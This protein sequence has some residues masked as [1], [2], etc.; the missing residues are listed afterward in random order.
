MA[1]LVRRVANS[2]FWYENF[3][4]AGKRFRGSLKTADHAVAARLAADRMATAKAEKNQVGND[5]CEWLKEIV[6]AAGYEVE[7]VMEDNQG[8]L[9]LLCAPSGIAWRRD[10]ATTR[11][12]SEAFARAAGRYRKTWGTK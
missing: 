9:L 10:R 11:G 8:R 2:R 4:I 1:S 5:P 12:L 3:T 6:T 7:N